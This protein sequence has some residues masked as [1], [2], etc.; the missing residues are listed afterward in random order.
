MTVLLHI[1]LLAGFYMV[2]IFLTSVFHLPIPGSI[3]GLLLLLAALLLRVC[4]L[5]WIEQG[6]SLHLQHISLLFI[7]P[8]LGAAHYLN[9]FQANGWKLAIILA[10]SSIVILLVTGWTAQ[11]YENQKKK[12]GEKK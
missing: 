9:V 8:I 10:I 11:W 3:V 6:A 4:K 12:R 7:P 2:G 1:V 5:S